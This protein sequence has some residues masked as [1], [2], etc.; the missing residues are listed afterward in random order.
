[1]GRTSSSLYRKRR[2]RVLSPR[3]LYCHICG[4]EIDKT[5]PWPHPMSAT[6]DHL[7]PVALGGSNLGPLLP[8]HHSCN[9]SRGTRDIGSFTPPIL[10]TENTAVDDAEEK[11]EFRW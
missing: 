8:A 10:R 9:S 11:A 5:L 7:T 6:A 1:M 2:A 3:V 4:G